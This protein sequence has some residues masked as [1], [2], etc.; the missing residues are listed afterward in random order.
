M[1][2]KE[3]TV[4]DIILCRDLIG[5]FLDDSDL[6]KGFRKCLGVTTPKLSKIYF[7]LTNLANNMAGR[8][9][10]PPPVVSRKTGEH[11]FADC[12][13]APRCVT[14]GADED[15]AFVGG[16]VCTFKSVK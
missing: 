13:G 12:G 11:R 7:K 9:S 15:D 3:L 8:G 5:V 2:N 1:K 14:C 4:N 10:T 6:N 16:A